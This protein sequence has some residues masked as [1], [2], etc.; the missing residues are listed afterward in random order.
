MAEQGGNVLSGGFRNIEDTGRRGKEEGESVLE[1]AKDWI[2]GAGDKATET[3]QQAKQKASG[4]YDEAKKSVNERTG[5]DEIQRVKDSGSGILDRVEHAFDDLKH[6]LKDKLHLDSS[7]SDD[8][9]M[10]PYLL[11]E[12]LPV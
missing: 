2:S 4:M 5:Q 12:F 1:R 3:A 8:E 11:S 9:S 7:P 10:V 6:T